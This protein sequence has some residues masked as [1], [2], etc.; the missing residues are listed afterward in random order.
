MK[1]TTLTHTAALLAAGTSCLTPAFSAPPPA[2][3]PPKASAMSAT[4][5]PI[6]RPATAWNQL[7][8]R[9]P[10]K[11]FHLY[12]NDLN[13]WIQE[14]NA[15]LR[16]QY[17]AAWVDGQPGNY[18]GSRNW[19]SGYRRFRA[20]WNARMLS[21]FKIQNVWNVGGVD[22]TGT[23][24]SS[25]REWRDHTQTSSSLYEAFVQYDDEQR[26][27]TLAFGKTNPQI[28]AENRVS[29]SSLPV[30]EF[31]VVESTV[32]FDSA[33]GFWAANDTQKDKLGYYAG[34]WSTTNDGNKQIWGT[35]QSCFTTLEL[36][37]NIDKTLLAKGRIYLD[38]VHSFAD[39]GRA[40]A[41][42][43]DTFVGPTYQDVLAVYYI[44][45][46]GSFGLTAE[47]LCAMHGNRQQAGDMFGFILLPSYRLTDRIEAVARFQYATGDRA[48]N[49]G[50]NRYV[51][52]L[53]SLSPGYAENYWALG[54]G[55]NFFLYPEQPARLKI[56]TLLEYGHSRVSSAQRGKNAGFTGWQFICGAYLNF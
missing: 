36:S 53:Q 43:R 47:A 18:A 27:Y 46:Q 13:P 23:W 52:A 42:D 16:I 44:G 29:S 35:W 51:K 41:R 49:V 34:V 10:A 5:A 48:I 32:C 33:W 39:G 25:R 37:Y 21:D 45:R 40:L 15:T 17:Q 55:L 38:W 22:H 1:A 30:P 4:Q 20:G 50:K 2:S 3:T 31:S 12:K 14:L 56:M 54:A 19:T 7:F 24:D 11:K 8:R 26:G 28:L 9:S 6:T